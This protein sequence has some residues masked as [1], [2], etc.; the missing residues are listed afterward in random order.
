MSQSVSG[1]LGRRTVWKSVWKGVGWTLL[2]MA[3]ALPSVG[4]QVYPVRQIRLVVPF[5]AGASDAT[6]RVVAELLREQLGASVVVENRPGANGNLGTA[7]V[8]RAAPDGYTLLLVSSSL[9]TSPSLYVNPGYDP[10]RD[11]SAVSLVGNVPLVAV[12]ANSVPAKSM[13]E[14]IEYARARRDRISYG[15]AGVGN[16]T[17]LVAQ[18]FL[19]SVGVQAVHV[20]YNIVPLADLFAS[21]LHFYMGTAS[22]LM[23][24][25]RDGRLMALATTGKAR[26]A[27]LPEVPT[28]DESLLPGFDRGI[29]YGIAA[30]AGT[31]QHVVAALAD[32][33]ARGMK[34]ATLRQRFDQMGLLPRV[35]GPKEF[36]AFINAELDHWT[37]IIRAS[38]LKPE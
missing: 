20:P 23:P 5:G 15:S 33:L 38:G 22:S 10:L 18:S 28:L 29:W 25:I 12:V 37:R 11:F 2:L 19:E 24:G 21:R 3:A 8:A 26:L 35:L 27:V 9:V 30:P 36:Q 17:H 4:A 13:R 14:F 16:M 1:I 31:P 6:G 34:D 7:A 32:A